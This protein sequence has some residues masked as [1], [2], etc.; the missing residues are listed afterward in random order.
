MV[1]LSSARALGLVG[2]VVGLVGC[3]DRAEAPA[4][5]S[6][7]AGSVLTVE[8]RRHDP[9]AAA[10]LRTEVVNL[11]A[12]VPPYCYATTAGGANPCATCH[13]A[14][15]GRNLLDDADLQ[16]SYAFADSARVN[17][18]HNLFVDRR[19][20][21]AAIADADLLAWIR[22]DNYRPLMAA[23]ASAGPDYPGFRPDLDLDDGFDRDGFARDGSGWRA[24]R[25]QPVPGHG[26]P[27]NGSYGDAFIRLPA[28]FTHAA[29]GAPDRALARLNYALVEAAVTASDGPIDRPVEP[30]D[31]RLVGVD[32]DGDGALGAAATR[33]RRLPARY[34]GAAA[35]EAVIA[36]ALPRGTELLHTVRYVDPDAP[37]L[38][39]RRLKELRYARKLE[40]L[41]A[42]GLSRAYGEAADEKSEGVVPVR[43][44]S[45]EA[46]YLNGYGWQLQG[47]IED[48]AGH[49]R[50][51]T[52]E[53]HAYCLGCHGGL[54]AT[55]DH[56]FAIARKV[57]GADGWRPQDLRGLR[58]R[59][60]GAAS[61]P[62][63]ATY[64]ARVGG[65][66]DFRANREMLARFFPDGVLD[67]AAVAR[68]AVAGDR[69]LAWLAAPSR[70][71]ALALGKAYLAIVREQS[72]ARGRDAVLAPIARA[73]REIVDEDT[74]LREQVDRSTGLVPRW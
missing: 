41:D 8:R 2:L 7:P 65:G 49:L 9:L 10:R 32:L 45:P 29:T 25:Y 17:P 54:G 33:I 72:F 13:T 19:G 6:A 35:T 59:P 68:A 46:G 57:P 5:A 48:A 50:V 64:L 31:E 26:W 55:V 37:D 53:E 70:A 47:F 39:A 24:V 62:E 27:T 1:S 12:A 36:G 15:R 3:G 40:V 74:G 73:H 66:D 71:R 14:G 16:G 52:A 69:D 63:A 23:L 43:Q 21:V 42:W 56:T 30:V 20:E 44:G 60:A 4:R 51:Q 34:A 38:A 61:T 67:R 18:W 22:E 11:D 58:D 28:A